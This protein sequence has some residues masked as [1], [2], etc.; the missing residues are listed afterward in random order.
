MNEATPADPVPA[1]SA[2]ESSFGDILS[3]FESERVRAPEAIQGTVLSI[4][5]DT[6]T[7]DIGRKHEGNVDAAQLRDRAGNLKVKPGD[8]IMVTIT[9]RDQ[10]GYYQLTTSKVKTPRDWSALEK[11]FQDKS[12]IHGTVEEVI[13]GGLRVDV[14]VR[15]FL[16]ASRSGTRDAAEMGALVGQQIR[17]R[18]TKLDVADEDVV[19]DRR[20]IL[21]E[22]ELKAKQERF[23]GLKEGD[24][25]EGVVRSLADYG[26]F[27]DIGGI[28]GLLHIGEM[29]WYR[30]AR[31]DE[32]V[33]VGETVTVRIV[34]IDAQTRKISLS[35]RHLTADPWTAAVDKYP[36]GSRIRGRVSKLADFGAF[37]ELEPGVEGLVHI[38]E[39]SW[40]RAKRPGDVVKRDE[41]VDVIVLGVNAADRKISLGIKQ[42]LGDPWEQAGGKYPA[43]TILEAPVK[44]L[45][46][47]GAFLALEDG[48][49]GFVHIGD[50][51][52]EKRLNHPSEV[53]S[54]GQKVRAVV[55]GLDDDR[56]RVRLGIKQLTPTDVDEYIQE[57]KPGDLVSGRIVE[58][59][60][61][62]ARVELGLDVFAS[63]RLPE[64]EG[65]GNAPATVN[66]GLSELSAL[67]SNKWKGGSTAA[68]RREPARA[69]Q[70]RQFRIL[71]LD[72]GRKFIEVELAG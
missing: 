30:V 67:L 35:L 33:S 64:G 72:S 36:A 52:P 24:T 25:V 44:N 71:A 5:G 27:V 32:V 14:G 57:H 66:A 18:I 50:I 10:D 46:K 68:P 19:V 38:S 43:G 58:I 34:K 6:V 2:E 9:G 69:G 59:S 42:V 41:L 53:L 40:A 70:V 51:H 56:R 21:E 29:A 48:I 39:M 17:C 22:E 49:D 65:A 7:V 13:K 47:F 62:S 1:D 37:V 28:D 8:P 63:C 45:A 3:Q 11:A 16:P 55:L 4:Q 54:A 23:A 15:A 60:T 20:V 26:A 61:Q 12:D 31:P